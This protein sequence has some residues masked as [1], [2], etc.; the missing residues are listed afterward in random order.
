MGAAVLTAI[1]ASCIGRDGNGG[2]AGWG[3]AASLLIRSLV[4]MGYVVAWR[5]ALTRCT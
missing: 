5:L 2:P 3:R 4:A 1:V